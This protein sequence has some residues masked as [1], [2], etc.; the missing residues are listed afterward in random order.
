MKIL[1]LIKQVP[2]T[3]TSIKVSGAGIV[4]AGIKWIVS[5]FDEHALEEALRLKEKTGGTVI[6]ASLGP[7]RVVEALRTAYALGADQ[8][9]HIKDDSYN[10]L[11]IGYA[12][13]VLAKFVEAEKPD[14]I[15]TGH[16][17][18]DSQSSM[19]PSMI[20]QTLGCANINNAIELKVEGNKVVV[21]REIEGG[22]AVMEASTPVVITAA[23]NLN[24]PR[25]P[26]LKG[27]M[28]AKK[29]QVDVKAA[30]SFG[31]GFAKVEIVSLELPPPRPPGRI[32]DGDAPETKAKELVKA[33]REEAKVI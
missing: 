2:D 6:A 27:I 15:L 9:I 22:S 24:E 32:I 5:P 16:V 23:K 25:Y 20:A 26:S 4:D 33:L 7:D 28:A 14:L 19:V 31:S 8:A 3:E 18:I 13:S 30:D 21:K 12:G 10:V 1:V 11:D 29:K 17:A